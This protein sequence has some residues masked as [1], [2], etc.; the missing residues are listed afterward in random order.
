MVLPDGPPVSMGLPPG[1]HRDDP[2]PAFVRSA[3]NLRWVQRDA[4][5][6]SQI[7]PMEATYSTTGV[8]RQGTP[9]R[10][11]P[12]PSG[13]TWLQ[14]R[15]WAFDFD[16]GGSRTRMLASTLRHHPSCVADAPNLDCSAQ[17]S[18]PRLRRG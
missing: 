7:A 2:V 12:A 5:K 1:S 13:P 15:V 9:V 6:K 14:Q 18:G 10:A 16:R 8:L 17:M 11:L 4:P 3:S